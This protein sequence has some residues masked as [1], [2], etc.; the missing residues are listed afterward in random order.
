MADPLNITLPPDIEIKVC[1]FLHLLSP[2]KISQYWFMFLNHCIFKATSLTSLTAFWCCSRHFCLATARSQSFCH[3]LISWLSS[4]VCGSRCSR[5]IGA[6]GC[7]LRVLRLSAW[8]NNNMVVNSG[9]QWFDIFICLI[10]FHTSEWT[11]ARR[12]LFWDT[13]VSAGLCGSFYIRELF[14]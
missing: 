14:I 9:G 2:R 6:A 8:H 1:K 7:I 4:G 10:C 11:F 12:N 13:L 3:W 5:G